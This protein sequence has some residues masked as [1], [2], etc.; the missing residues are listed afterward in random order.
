M[1]LLTIRHIPISVRNIMFLQNSILFC[2]CFKMSMVSYQCVFFKMAIMKYPFLWLQCRQ[3]IYI[4]TQE[5]VFT[6]Q[7]V[8]FLFVTTH[9][10]KISFLNKIYAVALIIFCQ[11][12]L[13]WISFVGKFL[14]NSYLL[15]NLFTC[16]YAKDI[17]RCFYRKLTA[18]TYVQ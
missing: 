15:L 11:Y 14:R 5:L 7:L 4:G 8:A 9:N 18:V 12:F 16:L 1:Q 13:L 3:I 2:F 17:Y 10:F 6:I